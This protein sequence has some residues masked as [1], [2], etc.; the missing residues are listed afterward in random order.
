ME[1]QYIQQLLHSYSE[2]IHKIHKSIK[3]KNFLMKR[4]HL[5]HRYR[6][7]ARGRSVPSVIVGNGLNSVFDFRILNSI[8][9]ILDWIWS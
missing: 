9:E 3:F 5:R 4:V 1:K 8:Y 2:T 7:F 6:R